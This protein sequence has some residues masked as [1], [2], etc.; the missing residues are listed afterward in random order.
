MSEY[1]EMLSREEER[2]SITK[3]VV[4]TIIVIL[5]IVGIFLVL[6][7]PW[8]RVEERRDSGTVV[9]GVCNPITKFG[10]A[11]KATQQMGYNDETGEIYTYYK[12]E[13]REV[14]FF[15][16]VNKETAYNNTTKIYRLGKIDIED[17]PG[18]KVF[19]YFEVFKQ[20]FSASKRF[21]IEY[22]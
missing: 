12:T 5:I 2:K 4:K 3:G 7:F 20:L 22:Q 14:G 11:I 17:E 6:F 8:Q 15:K 16:V 21:H 10:V 9:A 19:G 18:E 1:E 13:E